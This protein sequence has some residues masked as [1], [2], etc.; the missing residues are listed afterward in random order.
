MKKNKQTT[1]KQK[2]CKKSVGNFAGDD[3]NSRR[4]PYSWFEA[5][6]PFKIT[7]TEA[8]GVS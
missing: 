7:G 3:P 1:N 5:D 8:R 6:V 2:I 4:S